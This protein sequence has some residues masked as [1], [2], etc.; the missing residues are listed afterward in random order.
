MIHSFNESVNMFREIPRESHEA[1]GQIIDSKRPDIYSVRTYRRVIHRVRD[2]RRQEGEPQLR[3]GDIV[4]VNQL[5][6]HVW[7]IRAL[8]TANRDQDEVLQGESTGLSSS[9]AAI[10]LSSKDQQIATREDRISLQ[11]DKVDL[12]FFEKKAS[13]H[14]E[15]VH[16]DIPGYRAALQAGGIV[17]RPHENQEG[18]DSV[19]V[20]PKDE[21]TTLNI[22]GTVGSGEIAGHQHNFNLRV[23]IPIKSSPF[24]QVDEASLVSP[25]GSYTP[26]IMPIPDPPEV[27]VTP[28]TDSI[29]CEW[30]TVDKYKFYELQYLLG[31]KL[32]EDDVSINAPWMY[33]EVRSLMTSTTLEITLPYIVELLRAGSINLSSSH[34]LMLDEQEPMVSDTHVSFMLD[35]MALGYYYFI[36]RARAHSEHQAHTDWGYASVIIQDIEL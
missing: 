36:C 29:L 21:P 30:T 16:M 9:D 19:A 34:K 20:W 5:Y 6:K 28:E 26:S 2:A 4:H 18:L 15:E 14:A 17:L 7:E 8:L 31:Y 23:T 3:I 22:F 12:Q 25:G 35:E 32:A 10:T 24:I 11:G 1:I 27:T 33:G 13:L